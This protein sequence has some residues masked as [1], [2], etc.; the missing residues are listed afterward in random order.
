M[1]TLIPRITWAVLILFAGLLTGNSQALTPTNA[2]TADPGTYRAFIEKIALTC[3]TTKGFC[4]IKDAMG[5]W[6]CRKFPNVPPKSN[7]PRM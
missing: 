4:L 3:D 2:L 5:R 6:I 1:R 7:C